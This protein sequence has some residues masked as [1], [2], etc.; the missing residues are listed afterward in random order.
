M[1]EN[2]KLN[3]ST[4]KLI[5]QIAGVF[6]FVIS[7]LLIVN[8]IQYKRLDPVETELMNKLVERL[9]QDSDNVQLREDIRTVDLL[10]RKAYFTNQWQVRTGGYLLLICIA[11]L[12]I[13]MQILG[14]A[15]GKEVTITEN[16]N[17]FLEQKSARIWI[18]IAGAGIVCIAL[19]F[20]YLTHHELSREFTLAIE[21][22]KPQTTAAI[23]EVSKEDPKIEVEEIS[24]E[25][26]SNK[27]VEEAVSS[28]PVIKTKKQTETEVKQSTE[29]SQK[30]SKDP[31]E[32]A[33]SEPKKKAKTF[34]S[35]E[36]FRNNYPAFR[37]PGGNGIAYSKSIPENW[38]GTT[39]K[40][41][42]WK[43]KIP[44]HGFNSPVIWNNKLFLSGATATEREVYCI[45]RNTGALLWTAQANNIPGSPEKS[46]KVTDDTGLAAPSVT[47]DG[48]RVFAIFGNGDLIALDMDGKQLWAK[49]MGPTGNHY[50]HSSSLFLYEDILIVQYDTKVNPKLVGLSASSGNLIWSNLRDVKVS[51]ASPVVVNTGKQTE[52]LLVADPIVASYDPT[53][54][55]EN[56]QIDCIFGEVGPSVAYADGVVYAV[57]E[58]AKLVAIQIGDTPTILWE[59]DEYLSDVPSPVATKDLLFMATSYGVVVCY[60][61]KTG[62]KYWEQEFDN[63]FYSSP[64]LVDGKIY[65]LDMSGIT[66]IFAAA[67]EFVSIGQSPLGEDGMTTPAF[68]DGRIYIRGNEHLFC[69]GE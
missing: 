51:W 38:D 49:N 5:A 14:S 58:Y 24:T 26:E 56:W 53:T 41:I 27:G 57:N 33:L 29:E 31:V 66:H 34:P 50:G 48:S 15:K 60:D 19:F 45:N 10:A 25:T 23:A 2:K 37:G 30:T 59:N 18:A 55:E 61:S 62:K 64:I 7:M 9:N 6:A 28:E 65:L 16:S 32:K 42:I 52:I 20:A 43:F 21:A 11:V 4:W 40:N 1:E 35:T 69:I 63:G 44:L 22:V 36:E 12:V 47:T 17:S 3:I 8:Y 46:P 54:G 67:K 68:M 13:A 39:G